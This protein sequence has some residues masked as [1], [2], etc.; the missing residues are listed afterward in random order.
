MIN[1]CKERENIGQNKKLEKSY[2]KIQALVEELNKIE[3]PAEISSSINKDISKLDSF[4]GAD[5]MLTKAINKTYS[6]ILKL[7][8][9]ELGLVPRHYYQNIWMALGLSVFGVPLG[10]LYSTVTD[11]PGLFTIGIAM[12]LPIGL[13]IGIEKDKKAEKENKQ[14]QIG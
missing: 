13:A 3:I 2:Q 6:G 5:N 10:I 4:K 11:N 9:I 7:V 1:K 8:R 12:G 14:L